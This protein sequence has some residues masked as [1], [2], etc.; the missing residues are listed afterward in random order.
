MYCYIDAML[1][2]YYNCASGWICDLTSDF[3]NSFYLGS[4]LGALAG[5]LSMI[6]VL[7]VHC[8]R[9]SGTDTPGSSHE[10]ENR[11]RTIQDNIHNRNIEQNVVVDNM[12][13]QIVYSS[14]TSVNATY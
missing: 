9:K 7:R 3:N 4:S 12:G 10:L 11:D 14:K 2:T 1:Y 8:C 13:S 6:I 5:F